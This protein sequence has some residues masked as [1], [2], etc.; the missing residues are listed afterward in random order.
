MQLY[1]RDKERRRLRLQPIELNA[2][3][4]AIPK[5]RVMT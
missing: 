5:G 1:T 3:I 4:A 2:F